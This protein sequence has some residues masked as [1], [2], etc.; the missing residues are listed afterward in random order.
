MNDLDFAI[1][2]KAP[3]AFEL[4]E[5][6]VSEA[7]TVGQESGAQ[8]ILAVELAAAGFEITRLAIPEDIGL[9][10]AAGIS[11]QSYEGRYDLIGQRG[12]RNADRTLI[13]NGHMDVVPAQDTSAWTVAPFTPTRRDGWL[14]GRGAAD[15]KAGFVTGLLA[16]WAL[17][18]L[19]P[20]WMTGGLTVVSVIEE[21]CTGN[22]TLAAGRA[23][24][25]A[26]AA[27]LLEPT[28]LDVLLAR[29][30]IIWIEIEIDG[31]SGHAEAAQKSINPILAA[32]PVIDALLEFEKEMNEAHS[33]GVDADAT[34]KD[35]AHPYNVNIGKFQAGDWASSV[36]SISRLEIRVGHPQSW[37]S[38][39][40]FLQ[41][42]AAIDRVANS[43]EWLR[44]H[45]PRLT[46]NGYR[47]E[48]YA[49]DPTGEI[50]TLLSAAHAQAHGENPK[51]VS[52]GSTTDARFY[53]NQFDMPAIAYGPRSR[54]MHGADEAVELKSI[55]DTARTVA[56]FLS[57]WYEI[58]LNP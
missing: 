16:I 24:Y 47:A 57:D 17:D 51:L 14:I 34:F 23:G 40:A 37:T 22:G 31:L 52:V 7:S 18:E 19:S 5:R 38:E 32:I 12:A 56:R 36:P 43:D 58:E 30:G 3:R 20:G 49:Q 4:L 42:Q 29:I 26:D 46:M 33:L 27:L 13:I 35:I 41:V 50:V 45:P 44:S 25:L 54:N 6:L 21:E 8:E 53:L 28:N 39:E 10:Q 11:K 9:D 55:I 48:R 1:Q 2:E 15:M